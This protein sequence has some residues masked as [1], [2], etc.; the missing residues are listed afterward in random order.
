MVTDMAPWDQ[1]RCSR[2]PE[3]HPLGSW[4]CG[5]PQ[6]G[7]RVV[8][9][10]HRDWSGGM[11]RESH[12]ENTSHGRSQGPQATNLR[13]VPSTAQLSCWVFSPACPPQ[14]EPPPTSIILSHSALLT[15]D[16]AAYLTGDRCLH[17]SRRTPSPPSQSP[18]SQG[19]LQPPALRIPGHPLQ[20]LIAWSLSYKSFPP[21]RRDETVPDLIKNP[22]SCTPS[23][24]AH[25]FTSF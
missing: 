7:L 3:Q 1:N 19:C 16:P 21:A 20:G 2:G 23:A 12:T 15:P 11:S 18:S 17:I 5:G 13:R 25:I 4:Q 6:R 10:Y 8:T 9:L 24:A 22:S 14:Q